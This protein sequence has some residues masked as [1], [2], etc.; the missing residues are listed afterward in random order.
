MPHLT[1]RPT[2][3]HGACA[4]HF[5]IC[6]PRPAMRALRPTDRQAKHAGRVRSRDAVVD[7][8]RVFNKQSA[9]SRKRQFGAT[10]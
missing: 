10:K 1:G 8:F 3:A 4:K 6:S 5:E 2:L 7:V 9:V